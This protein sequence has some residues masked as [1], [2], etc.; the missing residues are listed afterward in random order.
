MC[1][2]MCVY[3]YWCIYS[4]SDKIYANLRAQTYL[5]VFKYTAIF[6]PTPAGG[7]EPLLC[8]SFS[9]LE[10]MLLLVLN[11]PHLLC[12][13]LVSLPHYLPLALFTIRILADL[14]LVQ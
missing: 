10:D 11:L 8:Y 6:H 5:G 2:S 13:F 9:L 14:L 4:W 1:I 7:A 3:I 12:S